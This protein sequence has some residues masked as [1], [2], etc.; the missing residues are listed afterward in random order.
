[1]IFLLDFDFMV[2]AMLVNSAA[3]G[4]SC[5]KNT[6]VD[7]FDDCK[8]YCKSTKNCTFNYTGDLCGDNGDLNCYC[9][10]TQSS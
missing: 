10:P 4:G 1:M 7:G 8:S 9:T 2:T 6:C 5:P 3:S